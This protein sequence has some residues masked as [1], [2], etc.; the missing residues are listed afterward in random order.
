MIRLSNEMQAVLDRKC[1][2]CGKSYGEHRAE[3]NACPI[4]KDNRQIGWTL[5][6]FKE[7]EK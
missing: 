6:T 3:D 4:T 2:I 5:A 7:I 1:A